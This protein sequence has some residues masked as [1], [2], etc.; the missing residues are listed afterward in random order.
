MKAQGQQQS[1]HDEGI[2]GVTEEHHAHDQVEYAHQQGEEE[3][4]PVASPER[5]DQL[6]DPAHHEQGAEECD[7]GQRTGEGH[8]HGRRADDDQNDPQRED[9]TP[10]P[11][12]RLQ[13]VTQDPAGQ[14][15]LGRRAHDR[16]LRDGTER[17]GRT[18][19]LSR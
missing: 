15:K 2:A 17:Q 10:V 1:D 9:P 11:L 5:T 18:G 7:R 16:G 19:P 4:A 6:G 8:R 3:T 13:L 12:D 14:A